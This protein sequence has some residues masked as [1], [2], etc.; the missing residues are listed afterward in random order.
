MTYKVLSLKW[1]PQTFADI[2]GQDHITQTLVNAFKQDRI[3]QGYLFTGPRGVGK[4]TTARIVAMALN[5]PGGPAA[6]FDSNTETAQEIADGRALDVLEIDGASNRGIEEI[7]N[8]REQIKFAP[9]NCAY[10]VI[11]IDE[12]HMLTTPAFNALLRTLEEPPPHG[13]FIFCTTDVHKVPATI[14]SRC[15]R[16]DFN[17]ISLRV[18][19]E[20][21]GFVIKA[22]NIKVEKE[23]VAAIARK[24]DGSM[25]DAL[26][27]L[28]QVI[29]FCGSTVRHK[30]VVKALGLIPQDL[31]F[32]FTRAVREK[33]N[34]LM[35][36]LLSRF[37][38][39]GVPAAEVLI[40]MGEH[41]RN[42]LY[43]G[44]K[45]GR[46][47]LEMNQEHQNL[48]DQ[49][50]AAWDKRDLLRI[51]QVL[52]DASAYIR[53]A[54]DSYLLLE[55]TALKL[56]ELDRSVS[57]DALLTGEIPIPA[58]MQ[59]TTSQSPATTGKK[60]T[61]PEQDAN[62]PSELDKEAKLAEPKTE[63]EKNDEQSSS[64]NVVSE[65]P[66]SDINDKRIV[67]PKDRKSPR[68]ALKDVEIAWPNI[69]ENIHRIRPSIGAVLE[70]STPV[71]YD[72]SIVTIK[73]S[74]QSAFNL[75]MV[76]KHATVVEEV[77]SNKLGQAL[78]IRLIEGKSKTPINSA[79]KDEKPSAEV[80]LDDEK[81]LDRIVELFDGEILR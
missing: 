35:I 59:P 12:V 18:I 73:G 32:D 63:E 20:R 38:G 9:M 79:R 43:A 76:E 72:G 4:T 28:D 6:D 19:S 25:R 81:T 78:R 39:F 34:E 55:M 71:D 24:A 46:E 45:N 44:I 60:I 36:K 57:I 30:D 15:Q 77:I 52:S 68:I 29:S 62:Q 14:I 3:A 54:E 80:N 64:E 65:T 49:E 42:L 13:K 58:D 69:M 17:R 70:N 74:G 31:Y 67:E 27:L 47:L 61:Y 40:G 1:R 33:D 48:Y 41:I 37:T 53:R 11:I 51:S 23:S 7:R 56:L 2:V 75:K 8:L 16:F 21:L 5:N 10:K 50:S 22:E 66:S 26:S